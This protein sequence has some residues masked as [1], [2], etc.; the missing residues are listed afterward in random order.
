MITENVALCR[1]LVRKFG[2]NE[3]VCEK[4]L[5]DFTEHKKFNRT[6]DELAAELKRPKEEIIAT[7]SDSCIPCEQE[8][9]S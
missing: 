2:G 3:V 1:I 4:I 7:I 6:V 9:T 8:S 5:N